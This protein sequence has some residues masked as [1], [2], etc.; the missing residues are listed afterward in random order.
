MVKIEK[1]T[2]KIINA[3][4]TKIGSLR[5]EKII[6]HCKP[7]YIYGKIKIYKHKALLRTI[8]AQIPLS[9]CNISK[10]TRLLNHTYLLKTP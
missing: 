9:I 6:A 4:N 3:N 1:K 5:L 10:T 8:I 7:G 2:N